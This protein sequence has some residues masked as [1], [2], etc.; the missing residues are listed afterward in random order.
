MCNCSFNAFAKID[1]VSTSPI[2]K[3]NR[4]C[5]KKDEM[6]TPE[7]LEALML[8]QRLA[9]WQ[10]QRKM[11]VYRQPSPL[12]MLPPPACPSWVAEVVSTY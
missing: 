7:T 6:N 8:C 1:P 2:F 4:D 11:S 10:E 3:V 9:I 12:R 5:Q